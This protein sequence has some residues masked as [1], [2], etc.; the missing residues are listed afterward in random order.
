MTRCL[1]LALAA[2][3]AGQLA[4]PGFAQEEGAP[5]PAIA[6]EVAGPPPQPAPAVSIDDAYAREFAFL[7]AQRRE[8]T[9][10]IEQTRIRNAEARASLQTDV[11]RAQNTVLA[12][13]QRL[14]RLNEQVTQSQ[15]QIALNAE[16][17]EILAATYQQAGATLEQEGISALDEEP[18]L[19]S[20]DAER[21]QIL[22]EEGLVLIQQLSTI[23][24]G[25]GSFY[26][27]D[28]AEVTGQILRV[29][30]IAAY[31]KAG[32]VAG[33]L[34]PAGGG[35][36][37][38]WPANVTDGVE[39][40]LA[41][42]GPEVIPVFLFESLA[43]SVQPREK[44]GPIDVIND[45]GTIGWV[46]V[47]LGLVGLVM[48]ILRIVFLQRSGSKISV[49]SDR[50]A[51]FVRSGDTDQALSFLRGKSNSPARVMTAALR[52]LDKD[53]DH[54]ED[55]VS[56]AILHESATLNR[57]GTAILVI[58][59][60]APLLGLLG[61]VTGMISTFDIITEFGTGDPKLLSGGIAIALVT[62]EL[63][64]IVAIPTLLIGNLL[65]GWSEGIKDDMEK[66][67]LHIINIS[68]DRKGQLKA[69][70]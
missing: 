39:A 60:V 70:A 33:V 58:A 42:R 26:R 54:I 49:L 1:R 24:R 61:T 43:K 38:V 55:I 3:A 25:T 19:S 8:L 68:Q 9:R 48:I 36:L 45:G 18:F 63:G 14:T 17:R 10:R 64:L 44:K 23:R 35:R 27:T 20:D 37:K 34:A 50:V 51:P 4:A 56:E 12:L 15:E 28:G 5:D 7:E 53:R 29:G 52:N 66:A 69:V 62:T 59:G 16:N 22:F 13:D 32:E 65:S 57:F 41:G 6:A 21:V 46:I 11:D 30:N 67:A 2:L 31:G 47:W 40:V